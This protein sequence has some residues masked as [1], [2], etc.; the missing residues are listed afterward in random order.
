MAGFFKRIDTVLLRVKNI[1]KACRW[2]QEVLGLEAAYI[3]EDDHR[4]AV[5]KIGEG[6][7]PLTLYELHSDEVMPARRFSTTYPILFAE[8]PETLYE[9]LKNKG[10]EVEE[11][12][13]DGRVTYFGFRDPDGN[14]LE[15]CYWRS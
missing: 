11:L 14:R 2:Y 13:D 5:F 10:V 3:G 7:T 12:E 9:T 4:I 6:E 8:N 1:K 15:V